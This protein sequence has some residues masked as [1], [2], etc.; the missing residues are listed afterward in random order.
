LE[1]VHNRSDSP[2]DG[3]REVGLPPGNYRVKA[4]ANGY[5]TVSVP[6]KIE[7]HRTTRIHLDDGPAQWQAGATPE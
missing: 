3:P 2:L 5:G 7:P 1:T 4:R 6:V